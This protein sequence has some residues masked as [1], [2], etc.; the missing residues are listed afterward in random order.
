MLFILFLTFLSSTTVLTQTIESYIHVTLESEFAFQPANNIELLQSSQI[1]SIIRCSAACVAN[2]QCR[3]FDY[4][5]SS[6]L[7]RLFEG[8]I[9]TGTIING[10]SK[11]GNLPLNVQFFLNIYNASCSLCVNNRYF[12][13]ASDGTCQCPLHTFWNGTICQNQLYQGSS[14]NMNISCRNDLGLI[15][16]TANICDIP[17]NATTVSFI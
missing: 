15:C 5:P 1:L 2:R 8:S 16:T 17:S 4:D 12:V 13:C 9:D 3:T 10:S 7:C 14:C 11:V 6:H